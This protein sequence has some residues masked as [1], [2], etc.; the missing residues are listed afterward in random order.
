MTTPRV[1]DATSSC[2]PAG[3]VGTYRYD[4]AND[5]WTW[6][7]EVYAMHGVDPASTPTSELLEQ[8]RH[9][10]DPETVVGLV[11]SL[12]AGGDRFSLLH[13]VVRADGDVRELVAV[14]EADAAPDGTVAVRGFYVDVSE[15]LEKRL[16]AAADEAVR[17]A[18]QHRAAI[19]QAKGALSLAYGLSEEEAMSLLRAVSSRRNVR[20]STLAERLC[21][22]VREGAGSTQALRRRMDDVLS[23][24]SRG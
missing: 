1:D 2:P 9:P 19:E 14:G 21:A 12:S 5:A 16:S 4:V 7:V 8:H 10:D 11:R 3:T 22:A 6:T 24:V 15:G 23:S 17:A 20:L 18:V 13:R